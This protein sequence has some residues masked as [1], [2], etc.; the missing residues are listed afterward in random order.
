M[1]K[2]ES[3]E[4]WIKVL[5]GTDEVQ[6]RRFSAL[7]ALEL[8]YGGIS[9]VSRFTGLSR[10]TIE[11]GISEIKSRKELKKSTRLR[12]EGGGRK[13]IV[14]NDPRIIKDIDNIME[15]NTAGDP[16]NHL[17]WTHKSTY[18]IADELKAKGHTIS[19]S[20]VGRLLK[21]Q[22]YSLQA[23][24][25][26]KE[27]CASPDRDE[28]FRYINKKVK[29]FAEIG[30]PVISVDTKKKELVGEFKNAGTNW[31]KKGEA[32]EVEVYDFRSTA[33]G[34]A[35]PYGAYDDQ[36]NEGFVNVGMT[37]DTA[38]FAVNSITQW[39]R[40]LGSK[41]YFQSKRLLICADGGGSNG[42]RNRGWKYFL[43]NFANVTGM[44]VTVCHYP[45]GTSKWNK[46]EHR[47]F[48][49]ISM[50]WR[51]KPLVSYKV[52]IELISATKTKNGLNIFA[53]LDG[54]EYEKGK[55]FSDK[56]ISKINIQKHEKHPKWNYSI[57]PQKLEV[58]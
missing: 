52:I 12:K 55:K 40:I 35:I 20:T 53:R 1:N 38:E 58:T 45:P 14:D 8:G 47:M 43:Q 31:K 42:S 22:G 10:S 49:F 34:V 16:M 32:D 36:R 9:K 51:G 19:E 13:R 50:N 11:K 4:L 7:H 54:G 41:H 5:S 3:E 30:D 48:S 15:K 6:T 56:E 44:E 33:K 23:N 25:K 24:K 17:V 57:S 28:Q 18:T 26:S 27:G 2:N 46:I 21:K 39:W 37:S 29:E